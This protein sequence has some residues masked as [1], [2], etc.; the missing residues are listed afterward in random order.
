MVGRKARKP[1]MMSDSS[2]RKQGEDSRV[3]QDQ[4]DGHSVLPVGEL[5]YLR[6]CGGVLR[7]LVV[8]DAEEAREPQRH[9]LFWVH[10]RTDGWNIRREGASDLKP[11]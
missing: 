1:E 2:E 4:S 3:H 8:S 5:V 7:L 9:A 11:S 6:S 10:L